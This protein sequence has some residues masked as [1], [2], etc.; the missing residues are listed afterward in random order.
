VTYEVTAADGCMDITTISKGFAA[1]VGEQPKT[2]HYVALGGDRFAAAEPNDGVHPMLAF[3][4][5]GRYLY[6]TRVV[7]RVPVSR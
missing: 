1:D 3:I 2:A 4:R 7:P 5:N 6:N